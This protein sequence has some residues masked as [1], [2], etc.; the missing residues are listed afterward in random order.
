VYFT[1]GSNMCS[2]VANG[3]GYLSELSIDF[4]DGQIQVEVSGENDPYWELS[5]A[6]IAKGIAMLNLSLT[7]SGMAYSGLNGTILS[8]NFLTPP[9][10]QENLDFVYIVGS[11]MLS[12]DGYTVDVIVEGKPDTITVKNASVKDW[13]VAKEG[14]IW[15]N[16]KT[17]SSGVLDISSATQLFYDASSLSA[18]S[19]IKNNGGLLELD[20]VNSGYAVD[21]NAPVYIITK[22]GEHEVDLDVSIA[23]DLDEDDFLFAYLDAD[24]DQVVSNIYIIKVDL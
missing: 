18:V 19:T 24:A 14:Q 13:L 20:G 16:I 23:K 15:N 9:T 4:L 11:W 8:A 7:S 22:T 21:D 10:L 17:T 1:R 6:M 2:V 3:N 5:G 12:V